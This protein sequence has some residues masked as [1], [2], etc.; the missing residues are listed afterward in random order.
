[1]DHVAGRLLS[2]RRPVFRTSDSAAI[3]LF[4]ESPTFELASTTAAGAPVLRTLHGVVVDG[5]LAFHGSPVGEKMEIEGRDAV[6][7]V[8]RTVASLPSFFLDPERACPATTLYDSAQAHGVVT[9]VSDPSKKARVLQALM[10]KLQPEGGYVPIDATDA[11]Y[12]KVVASIAVMEIQLDRVDGKS[13]LMQHKG[14][15]ERAK[16]VAG[17][18]RRGAPGDARAIERILEAA[19]SDERPALLRGPAGT[20]LHV[21]LADGDA[22]A[23]AALL[24]GTYWNDETEPAVIA[25][26]QE[27]STA[28]VGAKD[29]HGTLCAS[30]RALSDGAKHAWIYDVIVREDLRG[31]GV[32]D[33]VVR[34]LLEHPGVRRAANVHLG[35]RD[36]MAFYGAMGFVDK[37]TIARPYRSTEMVLRRHAGPARAT[38]T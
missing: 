35:T 18:W 20:T 25:S 29:E 31:R 6:V 36:A 19:P 7:A 28:W 15:A 32:G 24:A 8:S 30:A 9:R 3:R 12:R 2:M 37:A 1:M 38:E 33:A 26:A 27:G 11:M 17:L 5:C 10:D 13:K 23:A 14:A 34:L 4:E 16:V 22:E 21:A